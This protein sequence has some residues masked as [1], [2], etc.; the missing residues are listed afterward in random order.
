MSIFS[1]SDQF[2]IRVERPTITCLRTSQI[3]QQTKEF[4]DF[5]TRHSGSPN[6]LRQTDKPP[7]I[8]SVIRTIASTPFDVS[9]MA[10]SLSRRSEKIFGGSYKQNRRYFSQ[11]TFRYPFVWMPT[12]LL[13]VISQF[14]QK[15][16]ASSHLIRASK[17]ISLVSVPFKS[18]STQVNVELKDAK[19]YESIPGPK[20][21][22]FLRMMAPGGRY[23]KLELNEI[24]ETFRKDYGNIAKFPGF[25]GQRPMVMTFLP[26]EIEKVHRSEGKYPNRRPLDS[27]RYYREVH[28]PELY[29]A[30]SGL[31]TSQGHE[32]YEF[33]S[34]V[35]QVLMQPR[36]TKTYVPRIDEV[37]CD[38][39]DK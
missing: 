25:M 38:F 19:P 30:G 10:L 32:W 4:L 9:L 36:A 15:M 5:V 22:Q 39:I 35:Q 6:H 21:L 12:Q 8:F 26:E 23:H 17:N 31:T 18:L 3:T 2:S 34:K 28:K 13:G 20:V 24:V 7:K 29:P 33:R 37:A 14:S 1:F 11:F 16:L 27:F